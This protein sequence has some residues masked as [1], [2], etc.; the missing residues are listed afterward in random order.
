M[1]SGSE[2][3]GDD[4]LVRLTGPLVDKLLHLESTVEDLKFAQQ[5]LIEL[6]TRMATA[7]LVERHHVGEFEVVEVA[8]WNAAAIAYARCFVGGLRRA[9]A[10][11]LVPVDLR[12]THKGLIELRGQHIAHFDRK[13]NYE[14]V[15][16]RAR[17]SETETSV[18]IKL[19]T[20]GVKA[21]QPMPEVMPEYLGLVTQV[22]A[23]AESKY[24]HT[25]DD[26]EDALTTVNGSRLLQA[27]K[28]GSAVRLG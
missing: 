23:A 20:Q 2:V 12:G 26:I 16:V 21:M 3:A 4:V 15:S 5:A 19:D 10:T 6:Q 17:L 14:S 13:S 1:G 27:S 11:D 8:L 7:S 22:L 9:V 25:L 18:I 24:T 28:R